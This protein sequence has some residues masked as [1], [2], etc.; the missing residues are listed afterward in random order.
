MGID[1][2]NEQEA[3]LLLRDRATRKPAKDC[4]AV[5]DILNVEIITY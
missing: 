3:H 1:L 5:S 4:N 2:L